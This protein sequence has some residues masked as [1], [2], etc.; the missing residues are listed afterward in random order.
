[1][2]SQKAGESRDFSLFHLFDHSWKGLSADYS[3]LLPQA[4]RELWSHDVT[5]CWGN[6]SVYHIF[7]KLKHWQR[8][9]ACSPGVAQFC[10]ALCPNGRA[11]N[12]C[13]PV[14]RRH[15][16]TIICHWLCHFCK[17]SLSFPRL[18]RLDGWK[19]DDFS[20]SSASSAPWNSYWRI[21]PPR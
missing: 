4:G 15:W 10:N 9:T 8:S 5:G 13:P 14:S 2:E 3:L 6:K 7:T 21:F 12:P 19:E 16:K 17:F 1:M 20:S 18:N 11:E